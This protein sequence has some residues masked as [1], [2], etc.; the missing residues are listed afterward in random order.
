MLVA[1]LFTFAKIWGPAKCP[2]TDECIKNNL[3]THTHTHTHTKWKT[4][5]L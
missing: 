3:Y 4:T 1:V 2:P 5:Q